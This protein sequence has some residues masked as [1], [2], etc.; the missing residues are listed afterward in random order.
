MRNAI[1]KHFEGIGTVLFEPSL[2]AKHI[3]LSIRP[4]KGIRVAVPKGV[5]LQQAE[6][7]VLEKR[8][9]IQKNLLKV[10]KIEV[11]KNVISQKLQQLNIPEAKAMLVRR[12]A[13]LAERHG[14][15]YQKVTIRNQKTKWGSCSYKNN[16]S[17][18]IQLA[19]LPQRLIDYVLLHELVHT[20][21]KNHSP[22]FWTELDKYVGDAK[23]LRSQ[24]NAYLLDDENL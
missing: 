14:F 8:D 7:F 20:N 11:Q 3:N 12:L 15:S 18:N 21:I 16:I 2:K 19:F 22:Q 13:Q 23:A 5:S 4:F 6:A 10:K 1:Q 9:W 24:L 17:L